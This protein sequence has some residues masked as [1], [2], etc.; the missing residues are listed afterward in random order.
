MHCTVHAI[1]HHRYITNSDTAS[2][3][4]RCHVIELQELLE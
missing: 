1:Y 2:V 4:T 3:V